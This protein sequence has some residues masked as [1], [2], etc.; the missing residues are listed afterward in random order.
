MGDKNLA[1]LQKHRM[2]QAWSG[3]TGADTSGAPPGMHRL[4]KNL[5]RQMGAAGFT[6][7]DF[8]PRLHEDD[9]G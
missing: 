2:I 1:D 6:Y 9:E 7:D 3:I 8:T 4:W 5:W